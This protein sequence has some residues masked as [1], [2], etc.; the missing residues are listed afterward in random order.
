MNDSENLAIWD[1]LKTTPPQ[2]TKD[3]TYGGHKYKAIDP[4]W[5]LEQMT[6]LF[7]PCGMGWGYE[8]DATEVA[9]G[10]IV[11]A[12]VEVRVWYVVDSGTRYE[13]GPVT[14]A[15]ELISPKTSGGKVLHDDQ[16]NAILRTDTNAYKKAETD[17][18]TKAFSRIGLSA[19]V[20]MGKHDS[21]PYVQFMTEA[22]GAQGFQRLKTAAHAATSK[23]QRTTLGQLADD[24]LFD[25]RI[26]QGEYD[27]LT[28]LLTPVT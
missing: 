6:K 14:G 13:F 15:C 5:Q 4:Q 28:A 7:G 16:G 1:Q 22:H 18:L 20:F 8:T 27:E 11:I 17:A 23:H 25:E 10:N 3:V 2:Y 9:A 26:T 12:K 24:A 19:D 21:S